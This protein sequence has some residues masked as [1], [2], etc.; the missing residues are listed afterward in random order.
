MAGNTDS[1][2]SFSEQP[3]A[4]KTKTA[5]DIIRRFIEIPPT[6]IQAIPLISCLLIHTTE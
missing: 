3:E 6:S 5:K 2:E 4:S 1:A